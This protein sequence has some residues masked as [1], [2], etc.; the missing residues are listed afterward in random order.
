VLEENSLLEANMKKLNV[1]RMGM[2]LLASSLVLAACTPAPQIPVENAQVRVIHAIADGGSVNLFIDTVLKTPTATPLEFKGTYPATGYTG[3]APKKYTFEGIPTTSS[4]PLFT[5]DATFE[6]AKTYSVVAM[7]A[8]AGKVPPRPINAVVLEDN[9]SAPAS[10][11]FKIR[12]VHAVTDSTAATVSA[13]ITTP[14]ASLGGIPLALEYGKASQY[15]QFPAAAYQIR[16]TPVNEFAPILRD[17]QTFNFEAGRVYTVFAV[18][19][20]LG[21]SLPVLVDRN[22]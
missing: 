13:Y 6:S 2:V 3:L 12:V 10:G 5:F 14:G 18:D 21:S 20:A 17:L 19:C 16:L 11:N 15:V 9:N 7:G 22:P 4:K 8:V 1:G